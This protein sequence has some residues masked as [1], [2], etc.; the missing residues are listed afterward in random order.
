MSLSILIIL[1][2]TPA[3][4]L[5]SYILL[6]LTSSS[7]LLAPSLGHSHL[8]V[9]A[10]APSDWNVYYQ[11][12]SRSVPLFPFFLTDYACAL[13]IDDIPRPQAVERSRLVVS[14]S[15]LRASYQSISCLLPASNL[16]RV[17]FLIPLSFRSVLFSPGKFSVDH[18]P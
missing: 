16:L 8:H 9:D 3:K 4:L 5:W 2:T 18:A 12:F 11:S 17:Q 15:Y 7:P 14:I 1:H 10:V 13:W 6:L